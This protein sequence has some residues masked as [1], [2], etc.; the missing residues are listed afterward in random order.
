M[1]HVGRPLK[2]QLSHRSFTGWFPHALHSRNV[3]D[4]AVVYPSPDSLIPLPRLIE[5]SNLSSCNC[6]TWTGNCERFVTDQITTETLRPNLAVA[7]SVNKIHFKIT[8]FYDVLS[9]FLSQL[10]SHL[11]RHGLA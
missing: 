1:W 9:F 3:Q 2:V 4:R 5:D 8:S 10:K 7:L 6:S 11:F